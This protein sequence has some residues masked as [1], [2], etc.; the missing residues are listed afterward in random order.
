MKDSPT[1]PNMISV[2][3]PVFNAENTLTVCIESVRAQTYK[4]IEIILVDDCSTDDSFA[5][6]KEYEKKDFRIKAIHHE[7]NKGVSVARN[8]GLRLSTGEYIAFVDSDDT[9]EPKMYETMLASIQKNGA[10]I[11]I[12]QFKLRDTI[13]GITRS[14]V[15]NN[16][17]GLYSDSY[18]M[19]HI[20]YNEN[21][22]NYKDTLIQSVFNKL[23]K[24][25]V[26][27]QISFSGR[28][29][30]D[31]F[32]N[33]QIYSNKYKIIIIPDEFYYYYYSNNVKSLSHTVSIEQRLIFLDIFIKRCE[34]YDDSFIKTETMKKYCNMYLSFLK[35]EITYS[36]VKEGKFA[37]EYKEYVSILLH[38]NN[39]YSFKQKIRWRLAYISPR[40]YRLVVLARGNR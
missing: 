6:C 17:A 26:F 15:D 29:G 20:L 16:Y 10:D 7:D 2:I 8:S 31:C 33:N 34:I 13:G 23:Y 36:K 25:E 37:V 18:E 1:D 24:R 4:D 12:C 5:I 14:I 22:A 3:I 21:P 27:D 30:E 32:V 19:I 40:L 35:D 9:I 39:D 28:F 11:C 38:S